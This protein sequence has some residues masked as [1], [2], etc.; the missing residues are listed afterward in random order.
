MEHVLEVTD[1]TFEKEVVKSDIPAIV[2]FWAE[3]CV[4]CKMIAPVVDEIA[5]E[6]K[7]RIK[8]VKLNVDDNTKTATDLTVMNIPTLL[9]FKDGREAGRVSGVVSKRDLLKKIKE[10]FHD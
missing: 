7:G 2:D 1:S 4:P 3:W 8:I 9:F 10:L 5:K 6:F